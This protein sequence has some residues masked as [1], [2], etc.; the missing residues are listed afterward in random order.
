VSAAPLT[1]CGEQ[2]AQIRRS[3]HDRLIGGIVADVVVINDESGVE[4]GVLIGIVETDAEEI[5]VDRL[6]NRPIEH[7]AGQLNVQ[8]IG[9]D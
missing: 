9:D 4:R 1:H 7:R 6:I 3:V 5:S 8:L 2:V